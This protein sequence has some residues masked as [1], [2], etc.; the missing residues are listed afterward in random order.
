MCFLLLGLVWGKFNLADYQIDVVCYV[1]SDGSFCNGMKD[2]FEDPESAEDIAAQ[3][4][5]VKSF[6]I[7]GKDTASG[8]LK[9]LT[10]YPVLVYMSGST[11]GQGNDYFDV[12]NIKKNHMIQFMN[13][14]PEPEYPDVQSLKGH[15]LSM[16]R[17]GLQSQRGTVPSPEDLRKVSK[18]FIAPKTKADQG[19][20]VHIKGITE[21]NS[22]VDCLFAGLL[23]VELLS[24]VTVQAFVLYEAN[25][26]SSSNIL[27]ASYVLS[28][29]ETLMA[30]SQRLQATSVAVFAG[31]EGGPP[32]SNTVSKVV[33][34]QDGWE[35][36][37]S[38]GVPSPVTIPSSLLQKG[39]QFS[40]MQIAGPNEKVDV[41]LELM[42]SGTLAAQ[43]IAGGVNLSVQ[44]QSEVPGTIIAGVTQPGEKPGSPSMTVTFNG[45]GW[46]DVTNLA[47]AQFVFEGPVDVI[48]EPQNAKVDKRPEPDR[49]LGPG[50][51]DAPK[52]PV[53]PNS[54]NLGLIIG[55][56]VAAV[57]V[58]AAIIIGV[59][60]FLRYKKKKDQ[61]STSSGKEEQP[62]E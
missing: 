53:E 41:S 14:A 44:R 31:S 36:S 12:G 35:L 6:A 20:K 61:K 57:V 42:N 33:F 15:V 46:A 58:V 62:A 54:D 45:D 37:Y 25:V 7:V 24:T 56:T 9:D 11:T 26:V 55:C 2:M 48:N 51:E 40:I 17:L 52:G 8:C 43:T 49:P 16:A 23:D 29:P 32:P 34:K 28:S 30:N 27:K 1:A 4:I 47:D 5:N 3:G 19:M 39:G 18:H 60:L 59:V 38:A 21:G 50:A 10:S 22:K 13:A